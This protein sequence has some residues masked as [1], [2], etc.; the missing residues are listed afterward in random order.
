MYSYCG[1]YVVA[2]FYAHVDWRNALAVTFVPL[3]ECS[4]GFLAVLVAILG[5]TISPC[6]FFWQAAEEVRPA[7]SSDLRMPSETSGD[8]VVPE[9][10]ARAIDIASKGTN[11]LGVCMIVLYEAGYLKRLRPAPGGCKKDCVTGHRG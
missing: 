5:A 8:F 10:P 3:L 2:S 6:L 4:R 1:S 7:W 9:H 11:N